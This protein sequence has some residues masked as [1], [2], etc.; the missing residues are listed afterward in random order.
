MKYLK[1]LVSGLCISSVFFISKVNAKNYKLSLGASSFGQ[2]QVMGEIGD[3]IDFIY[4]SERFYN[5]Y[6]DLYNEK[7]CDNKFFSTEVDEDLYS[8]IKRSEGPDS[9]LLAAK[10]SL[11][12]EIDPHRGIRDEN[13]NDEKFL[14]EYFERDEK[15]ADVLSGC[16]GCTDLLIK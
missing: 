11:C 10:I 3:K 16:L 9:D 2:V 1:K 6:K 4:Y 5:K 14:S 13:E 7:F 15:L 8:A 12:E